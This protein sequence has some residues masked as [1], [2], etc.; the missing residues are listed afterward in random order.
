M[1]CFHIACQFRDTLLSGKHK[2][3]HYEAHRHD[4]LLSDGVAKIQY[5]WFLRSCLW[6]AAIKIFTSDIIV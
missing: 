2:H 5:L 6:W 4:V 3:K 1:K